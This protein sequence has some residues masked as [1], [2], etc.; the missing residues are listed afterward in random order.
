MHGGQQK[1]ARTYHRRGSAPKMAVTQYTT[2]GAVTELGENQEPNAHAMKRE[3]EE[4]SGH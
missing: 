4:D 2:E 3:A 1:E